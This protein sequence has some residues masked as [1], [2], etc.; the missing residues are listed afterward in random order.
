MPTKVALIGLGN[1][2]LG[3][4]GFGVHFIRHLESSFLFPEE[5]ALIDGG[6]AGFKLLNLMR[7][8]DVVFLFDIYR[9]DE[10]P[11]TIKIFD[12]ED[13]ELLEDSQFATVHQLGV[14]DALRMARFHGEVPAYFKAFAVVPERIAPGVGLSETLKRAIEPLSHLTF[15]EL[16]RWDLHPRPRRA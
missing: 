2:L 13:I 10:P 9:S 7:G 11:G 16:A 4:E 6:C 14:K 12:W 8:Q 1:I 3:D 5:I 15:Q